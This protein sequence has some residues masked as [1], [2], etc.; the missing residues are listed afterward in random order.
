MTEPA[1]SLPLKPRRNYGDACINPQFEVSSATPPCRLR[2]RL[3]AVG[4]TAKAH[5]NKGIMHVSP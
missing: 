4:V 2:P 1:A 3:R 5:L